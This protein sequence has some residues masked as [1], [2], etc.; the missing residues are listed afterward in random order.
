LVCNW[1]VDPVA[2]PKIKSPMT[3]Q[4]TILVVTDKRGK[5]CM[6]ANLISCKS[7]SAVTGSCICLRWLLCW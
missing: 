7:R 1:A 4:R 2:K 3:P 6:G 5:E